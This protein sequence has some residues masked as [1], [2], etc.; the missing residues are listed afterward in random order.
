[1]PDPVVISP[2][3]DVRDGLSPRGTLA[4][5]GAGAVAAVGISAL[6]RRKL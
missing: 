2:R 1:V 5:I 6:R 3:V 4:A